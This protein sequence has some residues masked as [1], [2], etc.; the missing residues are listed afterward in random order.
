MICVLNIAHVNFCSWT[1][2]QFVFFSLFSF[3]C[4]SILSLSRFF[5]SFFVVLFYVFVDEREKCTEKDVIKSS[6]LPIDRQDRRCQVR[7]LRRRRKRVN[8]ARVNELYF[9]IYKLWRI[10]IKSAETETI[11]FVCFVAFDN[12][13]K[14]TSL[15]FHRFCLTTN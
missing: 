2:F 1:N 12:I 3:I 9:D 11:H 15:Q 7:I 4:L 14:A 13:K 10:S 6:L 5:P 8:C